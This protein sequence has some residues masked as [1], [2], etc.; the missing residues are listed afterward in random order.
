V[1]EIRSNNSAGIAFLAQTE[2]TETQLYLYDG[3]LRQL[4]ETAGVNDG[5]VAE[6]TLALDCRTMNDRRLTVNSHR[7]Q[8]RP[9]RPVLELDVKFISAGPDEL[10]TA[11]FRPSWHRPGMPNLPVLLNPY[12]GPGFQLVMTHGAPYYAV[13]RW[14]A[15]QGFVVISTDGRGTPGRGPAYER[16]IHGDFVPRCSTTR[17]RLCRLL[18]IG[19][20][21]WT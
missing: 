18:P 10:R 21:T 17:W 6:G 9:E 2:P 8:S 20:A 12:A 11:V 5:F 4:T 14:F 15:E 13:S 7:I 19:T 3:E 1:A 16:A